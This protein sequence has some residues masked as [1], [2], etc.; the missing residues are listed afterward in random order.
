MFVVVLERKRVRIKRVA[1][2]QFP[3]AIIGGRFRQKLLEI[4]DQF[5]IRRINLARDFRFDAFLKIGALLIVQLVD[6]GRAF[7]ERRRENIFRGRL[8]DEVGHFLEHFF[9][10]EARRN[11]LLLLAHLQ[12]FERLIELLRQRVEPHDVILAVLRVEAAGGCSP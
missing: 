6:L 5:L 9:D 3:N 10:H 4:S 11:D 7:L 8:G 12:A 1:I 2:R